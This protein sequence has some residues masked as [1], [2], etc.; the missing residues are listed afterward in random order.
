[1]KE[2]LGITRQGD[3]YVYDWHESG[4]YDVIDMPEHQYASCFIIHDC[5]LIVLMSYSTNVAC[6]DT[7]TGNIWCP[8]TYSRTT[9]KHLGW[10]AKYLN[11]KYNL[12]I[13]YYDFKECN[14]LEHH[15]KKVK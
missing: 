4:Y 2:T 15:V 10:F 13:S 6:F 1:M 8:D 5:G 12:N 9:A 14:K 11:K 7:E 3:D